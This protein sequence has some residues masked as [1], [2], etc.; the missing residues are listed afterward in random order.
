MG[1]V[2]EDAG[3]YC[4]LKCLHLSR[5]VYICKDFVKIL[6][7]LWQNST[8]LLAFGDATQRA[9]TLS[10]FHQPKKPSQVR[11]WYKPGHF[12]RLFCSELCQCKHSF[13]SHIVIS[14]LGWGLHQGK[15]YDIY[16]CGGLNTSAVKTLLM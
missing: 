5:F 6:A 4:Q 1:D 7:I 2:V 3:F 13:R 15:Y 12:H 11:L 14:Y 8:I 10:V 9:I 16:G